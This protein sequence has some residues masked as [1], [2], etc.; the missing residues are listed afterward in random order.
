M[1]KSLLVSV[2][3]GVAVL[4]AAGLYAGTTV[5]DSVKMECKGYEKHTKGI[6]E[7]SHKKHAED[8]A[9]KAPELYKD[10]C[11]VCHHNDKGEALKDLKAGDDV[12]NCFE[13]HKKPGEKPKGKDAPKLDKKGELEYHAEAIHEN[14]KGCHKEYNTKTGKKDAPETCAKC[15]P[16]SE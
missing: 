10:G 7:F 6:V 5:P 9:A 1:K 16:K 15:H 12:K 8:Y 4:F 2:A 3:V 11:G 13:C 14:C